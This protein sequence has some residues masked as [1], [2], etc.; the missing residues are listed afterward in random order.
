MKKLKLYIFSFLCLLIF[1]FS[2]STP[3]MEKW[4]DF[5]VQKLHIPFARARY[6]DLYSGCFLR[7]YMDT[8]N[9]LKLK[10]Y[11][12]TR[13]N[14][15]L[16]IL[17][18]SYLANHLKK[19]NFIGV[20]TLILSDLRDKGVCFNLNKKKKNILIIE[21]SERTADWRLTDTA[22]SY[23]KLYPCNSVIRKTK[24][25]NENFIKYFFNPFINQNL[26]FNLFDYEF[27]KPVKETKAKVNFNLFN[28]VPPDVAVSANSKYLFL[29]ETVDP[30]RYESS[31]R[32]MG[33][34]EIVKIV[35]LMNLTEEHY[36]KLGFEKVY[37][38]IIPNPVSILDQGRMPYNHKIE[39]IRNTTW[40]KCGFIDVYDMFRNT[41][42][43]IY[44]KDD[45]HWNTYGV[46]LWVNEV[47]A[48]LLSY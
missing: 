31:F 29:A 33:E 18:D 27:F 37:F 3:L 38:S 25:I 24:E 5:R 14:I 21:C 34:I 43:Q 7:Q 26:E 12:T 32:N 1:I 42:K 35:Y 46:Q 48:E 4:A 19:E 36:K 10:E 2:Q 41:K 16:Y 17:H 40:M 15:D 23:P 45:S 30:A 8:A 11:K 6:G 28:R 47:N 39:R 9:H 22:L 20:D 13:N 44:R